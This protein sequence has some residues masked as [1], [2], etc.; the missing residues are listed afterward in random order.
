MGRE[1]DRALGRSGRTPN[2]GLQGFKRWLMECD[3]S[4]RRVGKALIVSVTCFVSLVTVLW[5]L[6]LNARGSDS[7]GCLGLMGRGPHGLTWKSRQFVSSTRFLTIITVYPIFL[8]LLVVPV[9]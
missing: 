9:N 1:P 2:S 3:S 6:L 5:I 4:L 8:F 7:I